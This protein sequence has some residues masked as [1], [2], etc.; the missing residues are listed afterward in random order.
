VHHP[1]A[2]N[3]RGRPQERSI[4]TDVAR[5]AQPPQAAP[6]DGDAFAYYGLIDLSV[7]IIQ[8]ERFYDFYL[9]DAGWGLLYTVLVGFPLVM[10]AARP[11]AQLCLQQLIVVSTAILIC[12]LITP[13]TGQLAPAVL[14]A[15]TGMV[16]SGLS[17]HGLVPIR[18]LSLHGI[19]KGM[20][21]LAVVAAVS[22]LAYAA[23]M[24][25]AAR[26]G[27]ADDDTWGLMHLPMQAAFALSVAGVT[28]L[29][30]LA[31]AAKSA[32]WQV[33]A[34]SAAASAAW[35][36]LLSVAYPGH[37]GSLG[38]IGGVAAIAWG[39]ALAVGIVIHHRTVRQSI[40][41]SVNPS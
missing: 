20:A 14:L 23:T 40:V 4:R 26:V 34:W 9:V 32:W 29:A 25:Q 5:H 27:H 31:D 33:P 1:G 22:S 36:G 19:N 37:L 39:V 18:G 17:G 8:D 11:R 7:V 16:L 10:F 35:L 30:V 38:R 2:A 12:A 3:T 13:A 28:V 6:N 15:V 24:I 21:V 41:P